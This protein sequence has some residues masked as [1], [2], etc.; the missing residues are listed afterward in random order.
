[1]E[2]MDVGFIGLGNMG[3]PMATRLVAAGCRLTVLDVRSEAMTPLVNAGARAAQSVEEVGDGVEIV[4]LSLPTPQDVEEVAD[5]LAKGRRVKIVV[6]LSTTGATVERDLAQRLERCG[7]TLIDCPV[8]GGPSG[9]KNGT[10]ALILAGKATAVDKIRPLLEPLGKLF[11]VS[12]SPGLAQI[13]KLLN[14]LL[15][16]TALVATSEVLTLGRK[17]GLDTKT[18]IDV[19]N[20]SSGRNSAT[21]H[22]IPNHV[23][24]GGYDFGIAVDLSR[25]DAMLCVEHAH[26]LGLGLPVGELV[27]KTLVE[28]VEKYGKN[29]DLTYVARNAADRAG[30]EF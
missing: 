19:M 17:S 8:S 20:A 9:A 12:E 7:I 5:R 30:V 4:F 23:M 6:D 14:N 16:L 10:L 28:V 2:S 27:G 3:Q 13:V 18:M 29:V 15:S 1:M 21:S 11:V 26:A 24:T 22:K 25:K